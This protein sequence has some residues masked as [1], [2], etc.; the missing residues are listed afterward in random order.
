MKKLLAIITNAAL[1]LPILLA[2]QAHAQSEAAAK[3]MI[4]PS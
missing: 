1:I 3:A 4:F 2:D